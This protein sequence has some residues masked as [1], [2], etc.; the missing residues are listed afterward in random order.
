[1]LR[2]IS[3]Q[4]ITVVNPW[5]EA[6]ALSLL[7]FAPNGSGRPWIGL[8]FEALRRSGSLLH[9]RILDLDGPSAGYVRD[10]ISRQALALNLTTELNL[11]V[12]DAAPLAW[13]EGKPL[14]VYWHLS[15]ALFVF[16]GSQSGFRY[17]CVKA[18]QSLEWKY[19]AGSDYRPGDVMTQ[20]LWELGRLSW[21]PA[22]R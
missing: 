17:I 14:S 18:G 7:R 22:P 6:P 13:T 4:T 16:A 9:P 11:H 5:T 2:P 8:K 21:G 1:M 19:D 12:E 3:L 15:N 20:Q 10:D